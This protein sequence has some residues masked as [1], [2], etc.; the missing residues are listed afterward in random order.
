MIHR[1]GERKKMRS[2]DKWDDVREKEGFGRIE[3]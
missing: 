2:S 3:K 1:G